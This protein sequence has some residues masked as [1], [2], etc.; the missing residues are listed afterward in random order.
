[1]SVGKRQAKGNWVGRAI[2]LGAAMGAA[3]LLL[4]VCLIRSY[5]GR[6]VI[7]G[8][9]AQTVLEEDGDMGALLDGV[10]A[11][12][13]RGQ[14]FPVEV[15]VYQDQDQSRQVQ[16]CPPGTYYLVYRCAG[17]IGGAAEPVN[18]LLEVRPA[19]REGPVIQG[20]RDLTVTVGGSVSYRDGVTVTDNMDPTVSLR[21]DASQV[22]LTQPGSYPVTYSAAD[23][24]GNETTATI[25]VTVE[26]AEDPPG[27]EEQT[28]RPSGGESG[29]GGSAQASEVT[30]EQLDEL[31]DRILKKI[32]NS[33]MS[34]KQKAKAIFDYVHKNIRY[35]GTSDKSGWVKGAYVGLTQ[36]R[37]DCFNYFAA[38][39]ELLTRAGI[40]NIDLER[41][42]GRTDHYWQLVDVGEGYYH[43]DACPHP[44]SFPI[45]SFLLTEAEVREYTQRCRSVRTNYYVYDYD[46]CPVTVV[47]TPAGDTGEKPPAGSQGGDAQPTGSSQSGDTQQGNENQGG[48]AQS[49]GETRPGGDSQQTGAPAGEG[50]TEQPPEHTGSG[51]D[52]SAGA[53]GEDQ[54]GTP[55][56]E[57]NG[58]SEGDQGGS[59]AGQEESS[60]QTGDR[61]NSE[62]SQDIKNLESQP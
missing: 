52:Q 45:T 43:F 16:S 22:N 20:T 5:Y 53:S 14:T 6:P 61:E 62:P 55:G 54:S 36:G 56:G 18:G 48:D 12:D 41:V 2:T 10:T 9:K 11:A 34:K 8:V 58:A 4:V 17:G 33:S 25:T 27:G 28:G 60:G 31:A 1:M 21:V 47:G 29:G 46:S 19:D 49:G 24:S 59:D 26:K 39:K 37:G 13:R 15:E 30:Q 42:G 57:H 32:T 50:N 35:V 3:C 51:Q 40:P 23:A 38:S 44:N 7:Q